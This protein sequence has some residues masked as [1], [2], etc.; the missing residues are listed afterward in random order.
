MIKVILVDDKIDFM[1]ALK[2]MLEQYEDIEVIG[3]ATNG[4]EAYE[5]CRYHHPD[6]VLMDLVMPIC[7]GV[8][9]TELIKTYDNNV[10]IIVLTTFYE[11]EKVS[12]AL[13][14]G[15]DGYILKEADTS[16]IITAIKNAMQGLGT[17]HKKVLKKVS[18]MLQPV[19]ETLKTLE[20]MGKNHTDKEIEIMRLV[21]DGLSN[22]EIARRL[23]Y[24]EGTVK[25]MLTGILAKANAKDRTQL[26]VYAI[27]NRLI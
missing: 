1:N 21:V 4:R 19:P 5:L 3:C 18:K 24:T 7:D 2:Y 27:R 10:K 20:M 6:A 11:D 8:K 9:G 13:E 23:C 15:A 12:M 26:A 17:I 22:R 25:N 14:K 16:E